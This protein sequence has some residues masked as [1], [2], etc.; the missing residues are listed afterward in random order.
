MKTRVTLPHE[1]SRL[2][3]T[4]G[5]LETTLV[6]HEGVEL[7]CFA[8]FVL[9]RTEEGRARLRAYYERYFE[10]ARQAGTGFVLEGPTW[11]ANPDWADK[12]GISRREL[13]ALNAAGVAIMHEMRAIH[14]T[15]DLPV[16]VSGCVGPRG[17]G[18][19][20]GELM[21][22]EQAEVYHREQVEVLADAGVDLVSAFTLTNTNEA[23]GFARAAATAGVRSVVSFTLET[24]GKLPSGEPLRDA[25]EG[26][27]TATGGSVAY[28][29]INCAH[30]THFEHVL[31]PGAAWVRRIQ[32][33]RANASVRSHAE[34]NESP[35]LDAGDPVELGSEYGALV[36]ALPHLRVL[37]GCCGT[38]DRHVREI[39]V[40]C[41][42][43]G[44]RSSASDVRTIGPCAASPAPSSASTTPRSSLG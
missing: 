26:V 15:A 13:R 17:D 37:G 18:Y 32:G 8:A 25:I 41:I 38:D 9:L 29:M 35:D 40:A 21:T 42:G 7:P 31:E 12:L 2:L 19:V 1:Q 28:Y 39:A 4:D 6:F 33:V 10:I 23:I 36:A 24:D 22:P 20:A 43:S 11:R 27:D 16:V 14:E 30:P 44:T 34:L 3:L 5:G